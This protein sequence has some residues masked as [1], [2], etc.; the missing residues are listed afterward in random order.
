MKIVLVYRKKMK[1]RYSLENVFDS[2]IPY[3]RTQYN[4]R[5]YFTGGWMCLIKDI[6]NLVF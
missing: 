6:F 1:G 5:V 3:I 4:I 2:L